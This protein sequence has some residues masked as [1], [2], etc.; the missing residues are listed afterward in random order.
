MCRLHPSMVVK[1]RNS[2][3]AAS[4]GKYC[5]ALH[6]FWCGMNE[7]Y[8]KWTKDGPNY[9]ARWSYQGQIQVQAEPVLQIV[10]PKYRRMSTVGDGYGPHGTTY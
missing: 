3:Y 10:G 4:L 1:L 2:D 9:T 8:S 7:R 5:M 6:I